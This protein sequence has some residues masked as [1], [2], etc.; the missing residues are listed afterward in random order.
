M[1]AEKKKKI[2]SSSKA[3][4][5]VQIWVP[6]KPLRSFPESCN[7]TLGHSASSKTRSLVHPR[8]NMEK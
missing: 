1:E 8:G 7:G 4:L 6:I 2:L 3:M 5:Y